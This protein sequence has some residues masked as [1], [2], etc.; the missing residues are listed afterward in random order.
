MANQ[1]SNDSFKAVVEAKYGMP[2]NEALRN[3]QR[4]GVTLQ[5]VAK[6]TGFREITVKKYA[7]RY[8]CK[9]TG[10]YKPKDYCYEDELNELYTA[11]R[12]DR[13]N[14]VNVLSRSWTRKKRA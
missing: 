2:I 4:Q 12:S 11:L 10:I 14:R 13:L 3:L 5:E 6:K 7:L 1:H 8:N 9:L